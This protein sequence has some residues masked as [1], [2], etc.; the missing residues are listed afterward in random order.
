[1]LF[2]SFIVYLYNSFCSYIT[3]VVRNKKGVITKIVMKSCSL[4]WKFVVYVTSQSRLGVLS[5]LNTRRWCR[6]A[7]YGRNQHDS[8]GFRTFGQVRIRMVYTYLSYL[9]VFWCRPAMESFTVICILELLLA[10]EGKCP[11]LHRGTQI[12]SVPVHMVFSGYIQWVLSFRFS[13]VPVID[14]GGIPFSTQSTIAS[15]TLWAVSLTM[16]VAVPRVPWPKAQA[17]CPTA[18]WFNPGTRNNL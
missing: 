15:N 8:F 1:M 7:E 11:G 9:F 4:C 12:H 2:W 5:V 18:Q 16:L 13:S 10:G 3:V 14:G 6:S 17:P